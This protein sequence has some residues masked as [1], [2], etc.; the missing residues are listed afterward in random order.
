MLKSLQSRTPTWASEIWNLIGWKT[1]FPTCAEQGRIEPS[2]RAVPLHAEAGAPAAGPWGSDINSHSLPPKGWTDRRVC[3]SGCS[4]LE[5]FLPGVHRAPR[6]SQALLPWEL[7]D[8]E[9]LAL[10]CTKASSPPQPNR[11]HVGPLFA[12]PPWH[13]TPHLHRHPIRKTIPDFLLTPEFPM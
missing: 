4:F 11:A 3:H 1:W 7:Q 6:G 10:L 12:P 9:N 8:Q 5:R 13:R 2:G